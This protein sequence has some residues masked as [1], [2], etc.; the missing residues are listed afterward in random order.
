MSSSTD[1]LP[2]APYSPELLA[3]LHAD[4]LP[5]DVSSRLWPLVRRD[6][7]S[8]RIL[9]G[10]DAVS[11]R[12]RE[13]GEDPTG[14]LTIP[15]DVV[16]R[17]DRTID[18]VEQSAPRSSDPVVVPFRSRS[19]HLVVGI[20]AAAAFLAVGSIVFATVWRTPDASESVAAGPS[21]PAPEGSLVLDSNDLDSGFAFGIIGKR[22]P[23]AL[24]DPVDLASC[25]AANSVDSTTP[26][27]G[28]SQV[29]VDGRDGTLLV[30]AGAQ[31][32]RFIALAVGHECGG[33]NPDILTRRDIG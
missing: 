3:E 31:P 16:E 27:L 30:L 20:A 6:E 15:A 28:S 4:A 29:R 10:L 11:A 2:D 7:E 22:D 12:L 1:A 19:R 14:T 17:I 5:E 18:S 24:S 23:G 9:A 8:M 13:V 32:G 33:N 26:V 21:S 25:L